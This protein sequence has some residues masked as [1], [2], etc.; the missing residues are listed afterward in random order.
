MKKTSGFASVVVCF[1]VSLAL[2]AQAL[3]Q[4]PHSAIVGRVVDASGAVLQG[5]Q[6]VVAAEG[7]AQPLDTTVA[8]DR[9]GEFSL[10]NLAPG[11]YALVVT[12]VGFKTFQTE[13]T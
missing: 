13:I 4:T 12:Y 1:L 8:S 5:A 3:A 10:S 11:Q 2:A 9:Q 7:G 6:V